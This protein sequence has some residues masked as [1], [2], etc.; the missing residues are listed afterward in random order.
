M[1]D[2]VGRGLPPG[3]SVTVTVNE[4]G[5]ANYFVTWLPPADANGDV[6]FPYGRNGS[7]PVVFTVTGGGK[8]V[9]WEYTWS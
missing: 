3:A 4:I 2:C 8:T 9:T 1:M 5:G 6:P 7:G